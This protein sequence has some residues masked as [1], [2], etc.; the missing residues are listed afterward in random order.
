MKKNVYRI[1]VCGDRHKIAKH[2]EGSLDNDVDLPDLKWADSF[3]ESIETDLLFSIKKEIEKTDIDDKNI[4]IVCRLDVGDVDEYRNHI[5]SCSKIVP[6]KLRKIIN[7]AIDWNLNMLEEVMDVT[8][9][10]RTRK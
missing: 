7:Q 6:R 9:T 3:I 10:E 5:W 2:F 1:F 4:S 8:K